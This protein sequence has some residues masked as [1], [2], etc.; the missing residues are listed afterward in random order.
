MVTTSDEK[1]NP[2]SFEWRHGTY[3]VIEI[4]GTW[5]HRNRWW[6]SRAA[7]DL[8]LATYPS[9]RYYFR[10]QLPGLAFFEID[11]DAAVNDGNWDLILD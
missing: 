11:D 4:I 10:V 7:A 8:G 2:V 6:V 3:E 9:D 5:H 1:G